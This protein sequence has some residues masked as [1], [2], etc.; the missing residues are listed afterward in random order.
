MRNSLRV[1]APSYS[2]KSLEPLY[3]GAEL[4]SGE[5]TNATASITQYERYCALLDDG[6]N[7]EAAGVLKEIKDYNQLRLPV[8]A[9]TAGLAA[10]A[11]L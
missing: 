11:G 3:M 10:A 6:H 5:V 9:P 7:D 1:G 2:L 8:D 4:R